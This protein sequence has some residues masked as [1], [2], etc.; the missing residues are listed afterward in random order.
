MY[1][2]KIH[3]RHLRYWQRV[4]AKTPSVSLLQEHEEQLKYEYNSQIAYRKGR[5]KKEKRGRE[6]ER[7]GAGSVFF[8]ATI[9][10]ITL[11][12]AEYHRLKS[13][14]PQCH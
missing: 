8:G 11:R 12:L 4:A 13:I 1:M 14:T 3:C 6:R 9:Y 10:L 2:A 7:E 5:G